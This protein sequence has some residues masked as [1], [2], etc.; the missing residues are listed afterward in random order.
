MRLRVGLLAV[1]LAFRFEISVSLTS[2]V[3]NFW[4][5]VLADFSREYLVMSK[6][7]QEIILATRPAVFRDFPNSTCIADCF[8]VFVD[9]AQNML[10]RGCTFSPYKSHNTAK[11][12]HELLRTVLLC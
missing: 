7:P 3:F 11:V 2:K 5:E 8:E 9:R 10:K 6:L 1:D 4:I 12:L